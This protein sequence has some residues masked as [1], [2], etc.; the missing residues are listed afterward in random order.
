MIHPLLLG[1][2]ALLI[3][4]HYMARGGLHFKENTSF[5]V[6]ERI[7]RFAP[8]LFTAFSANLSLASSLPLLVT[9]FLVYRKKD[10]SLHRE[11]SFAVR[12]QETIKIFENREPPLHKIAQIYNMGFSLLSFLTLLLVGDPQY[13]L[14]MWCHLSVLIFGLGPLIAHDIIMAF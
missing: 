14:L 12:N 1:T 8:P 13:A 5:T 10:E 6:V 4:C 3:N 9:A 2:S 7:M 11:I